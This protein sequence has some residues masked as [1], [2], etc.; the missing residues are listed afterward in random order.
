MRVNR[1]S[2]AGT[3]LVVDNSSKFYT[4]CVFFWPLVSIPFPNYEVVGLQPQS[5]DIPALV[6][7]HPPSKFS[8]PP[9]SKMHSSDNTR[10]TTD[11]QWLH[12]WPI[13]WHL[14]TMYSTYSLSP[15]SYGQK[16]D[17]KAYRDGGGRLGGIWDTVTSNLVPRWKVRGLCSPLNE[18]P[19][20]LPLPGSVR[21]CYRVWD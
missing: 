19:D 6:S 17:K 21:I 3:R 12:L 8:T 7:V 18:H 9:T 14:G 5:V 15:T 11:R 1:T 4:V 20:N 13:L 16:W 2:W 10:Q